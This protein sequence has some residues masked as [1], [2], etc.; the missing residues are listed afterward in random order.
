[1]KDRQ[2]TR[3]EDP[4]PDHAGRATTPEPAP[5][6]EA[7]IALAHAR[8]QGIPYETGNQWLARL[9]DEITNPQYPLGPVVTKPGAFPGN[10]RQGSGPCGFRV[11]RIAHA[12]LHSSSLGHSD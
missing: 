5:T 6:P 1:M 10:G 3:M 7:L 2:V 9:P 4:P 11:W 12:Q 8:H